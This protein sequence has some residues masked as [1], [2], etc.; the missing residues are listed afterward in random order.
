MGRRNI[1]LFNQTWP[2]GDGL[3]YESTHKVMCGN[4]VKSSTPTV[5]IPWCVLMVDAAD[6]RQYSTRFSYQVWEGSTHHPGW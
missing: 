1:K 3:G 6:N 5:A 2:L 4:C